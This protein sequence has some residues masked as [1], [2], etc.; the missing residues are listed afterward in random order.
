MDSNCGVLLE[1]TLQDVMQAVMRTKHYELARSLC[2]QE[3]DGSVEPHR[4][5]ELRKH[6]LDGLL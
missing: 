3:F 6:E 1:M 4:P 2:E 5:G